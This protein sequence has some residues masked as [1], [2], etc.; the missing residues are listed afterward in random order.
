MREIRRLDSKILLITNNPYVSKLL[1]QQYMID[2][3]TEDIKDALEHIRKKDFDLVVLDMGPLGIEGI[4]V[5]QDI[6]QNSPKSLILAINVDSSLVNDLTESNIYGFVHGLNFYKIESTIYKALNTIALSKEVEFFNLYLS[7]KYNL[8]F[9]IGKSNRMKNIYKQ[10][11]KISMFP[12]STVLITGETGVGKGI[13]ARIIHFQS[14][15]SKK[16]FVSINCSAIP[17]NLLESELFG[18][19]KGAFTDAKF[20]KKGLFEIAQGGTV[21]LDEIGDIDPYIQVK[22]LHV[23]EEKKFRRVGGISEIKVDIRIIAST[24]QDLKEAVKKGQFRED[25]FYRLNVVSI[26]IPPLRERKEDI[27]IFTKYFIDKFNREFGKKVKEFHP[28]T[29]KFLLNYSFPGNIRELKNMIERAMILGNND[30]I[31]PYELFPDFHLE[32]GEAK[33]D[34]RFFYGTP[35][36][37]EVENRYIKY[38]LEKTRGNKELAAKIL[39][40]GRAT[41]FRKLKEVSY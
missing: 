13:V 6:Q 11:E 31:M 18:Y 5:I 40:I 19:E 17:S 28:L 37:K 2:V 15:R 10:L 20:A 16:P 22:L 39:G 9:V 33:S 25:L 26:Y 36:L 23:L 4:D 34:N 35:T 8:E 41:L 32:S 27:L 12:N 14:N 21:Y 30:I 29:K 3:T 24:N 1:T 38:V 7:E